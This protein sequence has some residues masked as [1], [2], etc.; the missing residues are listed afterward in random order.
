MTNHHAEAI[1]QANKAARA[2]KTSTVG[3]RWVYVFVA[4]LIGGPLLYIG[5]PFYVAATFALVS[6][7]GVW[8]ARYTRWP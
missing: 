8:V 2:Y 4:L 5:F 6:M 3:W 7:A 1:R